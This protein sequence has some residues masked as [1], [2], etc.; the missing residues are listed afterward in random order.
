MIR[1]SGARHNSLLR[2]AAGIA[3]P[4]TLMVTS[5]TEARFFRHSS[6]ERPHSLAIIGPCF[7]RGLA[8]FTHL[9]I[10]ISM[11]SSDYHSLKRLIKNE[12]MK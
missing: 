10:K 8:C 6:V 3:C 9:G 2:R 7:I 12:I 5:L 11:F 4:D 1:S